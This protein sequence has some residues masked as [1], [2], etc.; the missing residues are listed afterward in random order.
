MSGDEQRQAF[1][2][3]EGDRYFERN[4]AAL[5]TYDGTADPVRRCL[6]AAG[7][8]PVSILEIGAATGTR[9]AALCA[10]FGAHGVAVEPSEAAVA[11][12]R[13]THPGVEFHVATMDDLPDIG[14][15]DLVIVNFVLHWVDRSLLLRTIAEIDRLLADGGYLVIGDF[16]PTNFLHVPY[17]H[18]ADQS[19]GTFKQNY[20]APFLAS[21]IY[22]AVGMLTANHSAKGLFAVA[23]ECERTGVWL[24]QKN[25]TAHYAPA[26]TAPR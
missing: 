21:G 14:P 16:F 25:L 6:D 4:R 18:L 8:R 9:V 20:A 5:A 17:H 3:G 23:E 7:A 15:F 2:L 10:A 22:H 12:G 26:G 24:L 11:E 13:A 19:V 1:E